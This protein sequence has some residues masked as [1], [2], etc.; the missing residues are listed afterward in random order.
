MTKNIR[1]IVSGVIVSSDNKILLGRQ[2][3]S[4]GGVYL[5]CWHIPGGGIEVGESRLAALKREIKEETGLDI[6]GADIKLIDDTKKGV[7]EKTLKDTGEK[8]LCH[9]SFDDFL[10]KINESSGKL[11]LNDTK[12]MINLTWFSPEELSNIEVPPPTT[13]LF[14]KLGYIS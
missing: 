4:T 2:D 5:N 6:D 13:A 12:E 3:N 14:K 8:V 10:V 9:M 1:E 7:S 11:K